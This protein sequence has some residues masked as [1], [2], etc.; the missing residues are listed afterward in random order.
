MLRLI[1]KTVQQKEREVETRGGDRNEGLTTKTNEQRW[2]NQMN[3]TTKKSESRS[4][5][6]RFSLWGKN[7]TR[8][9][10]DVYQFAENVTV[11]AVTSVNKLLYQL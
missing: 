3:R 4:Q 9:G 5:K 11:Y 1:N 2:K 8:S 6:F 10:A 7:K